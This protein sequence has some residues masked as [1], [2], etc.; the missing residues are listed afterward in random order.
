MKQ[1]W[2]ASMIWRRRSVR[3][4]SLIFGIAHPFV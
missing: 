1:R 3:R 4:S 2:A